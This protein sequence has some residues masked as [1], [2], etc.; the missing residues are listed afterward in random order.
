[1][2]LSDFISDALRS[3]VEITKPVMKSRLCR[4]WWQQEAPDL[5]FD[6]TDTTNDAGNDVEN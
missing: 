6:Y 1:M 2:E 4:I 3:T 5:T